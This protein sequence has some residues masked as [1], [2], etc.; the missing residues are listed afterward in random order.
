MN[1]AISLN[2]Q[3]DPEP[4]PSVENAYRMSQE[5]FAKWKAEVEIR[6]R[7]LEATVDVIQA[8]RART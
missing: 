5:D 7:V 8:Q 1:D 6:L 3:P 2:L 4:E